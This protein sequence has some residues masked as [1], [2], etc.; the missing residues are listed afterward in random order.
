MQ[1]RS[2]FQND[3]HTFD[4]LIFH[5]RS[6]QIGVDLPR[7]RPRRGGRRKQKQSNLNEHHPHMSLSLI[8][9]SISD[10]RD[11]LAESRLEIPVRI[12]DH[13]HHATTVRQSCVN[14][15]NLIS[16]TTQH[17]RV[18]VNRSQVLS[19]YCFLTHNHA[20]R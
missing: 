19:S 3:T 18:S 16:I 20:A 11:L 15:N 1:S 13:V 10:D 12:T 5:F 2:T 14:F 8:E 6:L 4:F 9:R 17:S 7:K